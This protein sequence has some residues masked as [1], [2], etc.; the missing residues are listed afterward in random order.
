VF[1]T[2]T[3]QVHYD[4]FNGRWGEEAELHKF[5]QAY[6]CEKV[7]SEAHAKGHTMTEQQL[8]NGSIK[9]TVHVGGAI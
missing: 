8:D 6:A 9:L 1:H 2:E 7:R 4:T 5:L 3:G